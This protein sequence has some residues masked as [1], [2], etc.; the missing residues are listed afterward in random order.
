MATTGTHPHGSLQSGNVADELAKAGASLRVVVVSPARP[1]SDGDATHLSVEALAGQM[2]IWPRHAD[3]VAALGT[4]GL[5]IHRKGGAVDRLAISG[6]FLKVGGRNVTIL[7]DRA[8][9]PADVDEAAVRKELEA[10]L[11]GL[12]HPRSDEEFESLLCDRAWAQA[13]LRLKG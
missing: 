8:V 5:A 11:A 9:T 7:V 13:R 12:R 2:G 1:L 6:G 3:L 10:A 4:G